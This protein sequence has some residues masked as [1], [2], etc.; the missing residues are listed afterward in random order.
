MPSCRVSSSGSLRCGGTTAVLTPPL[1]TL[2]LGIGVAV[3]RAAVP[4]SPDGV[5]GAYGGAYPVRPPARRAIR[6]AS[7][8]PNVPL[9]R[10]PSTFPGAVALT[11]PRVARVSLPAR[12]ARSRATERETPEIAVAM[13]PKVPVAKGGRVAPT[14]SP[15]AKVPETAGL[16]V[17]DGAQA[18]LHTG[19][20]GVGA[21]ATSGHV[22]GG[23]KTPDKPR[24][25]LASG[26]GSMRLVVPQAGQPVFAI[27]QQST[28]P[29]GARGMRVAE[30][31][32]HLPAVA[33]Y[34]TKF[35]EGR[36]PRLLE[37]ARGKGV[38]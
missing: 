22:S 21:R 17:L 1:P 32:L 6:V 11:V 16:A 14:T 31:S 3:V 15:L 4:A 10:A 12:D 25:L 7:G 23:P 33:N 29:T 34:R 30:A 9:A 38:H 20:A 37:K 36:G 18:T 2:G 24:P 19:G 5:G 8:P 13:G 35:E 27:A 28:A 26:A